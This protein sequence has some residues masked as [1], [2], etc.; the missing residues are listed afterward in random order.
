MDQPI[1]Q[2][3]QFVFQ[4]ALTFAE[5]CVIVGYLILDAADRALPDAQDPAN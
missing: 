1:P 2:I 4:A 3:K 5:L